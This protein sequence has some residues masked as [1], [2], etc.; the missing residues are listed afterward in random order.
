M[1]LACHFLKMHVPP[2]L[3]CRQMGTT[4]SNSIWVAPEAPIL[5]ESVT[6]HNFDYRYK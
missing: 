1:P 4:T 5:V 2:Q 3:L 6:N